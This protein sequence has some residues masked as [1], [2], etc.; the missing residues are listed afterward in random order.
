MKMFLLEAWCWTYGVG[1]WIVDHRNILAVITTLAVIGKLYWS[2]FKTQT[3]I[4]STQ[5]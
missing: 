2:A 3:M 4:R 1:N 5:R